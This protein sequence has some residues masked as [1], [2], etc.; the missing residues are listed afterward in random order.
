AMG[1]SF[2]ETF[3]RKRLASSAYACLESLRN[4]HQKLIGLSTESAESD[5]TPED[6]AQRDLF[7][8]QVTLPGGLSE[9]E[10]L[11]DLI[12]RAEKIPLGEE[13]KVKALLDLLRRLGDQKVIVFTEFR[14]TQQMIE[15]VLDRAGLAGQYVS[16][17]GDTSAAER[18]V[19]RRRFLESPQV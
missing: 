3:L 1:V 8:E 10:L 16:Y 9:I 5:D 2:L 19:I 11:A 6:I 12:T 17:H 18:E 7:V 13:A 4:R 15:R 14:D